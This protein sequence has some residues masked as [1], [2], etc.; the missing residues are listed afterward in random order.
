MD[1]AQDMYRKSD[2]VMT[3]YYPLNGDFTVKDPDVI[4]DDFQTL[5]D[6]FP[7]KE[8]LMTEIGYPIQPR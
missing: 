3:T 2:E 5:V 1:I 7:G 8:I 6:L 4:L